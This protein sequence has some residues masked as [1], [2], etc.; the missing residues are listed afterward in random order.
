MQTFMILCGL[1][2]LV[3]SGSIGMILDIKYHIK[4]PALFWFIGCICGFLGG[5]LIFLA[6]NQGS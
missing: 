5:L 4:F 3:G 6:T 1:A 2:I